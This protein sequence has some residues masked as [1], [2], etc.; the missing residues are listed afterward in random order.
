MFPRQ[1][2]RGTGRGP[3][4]GAVDIQGLLG[5][6][7]HGAGEARMHDR[8]PRD[9]HRTR[10]AGSLWIWVVI[11]GSAACGTTVIQSETGGTTGGG[12]AGSGTAGGGTAG[13][14]TGCAS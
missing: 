13:A 4:I 2:R 11:A 7:Y 6:R 5:S 14:P 8:R 10:R 1:P 9:T 12:A 3:E